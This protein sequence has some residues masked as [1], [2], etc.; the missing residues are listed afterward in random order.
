MSGDSLEPFGKETARATGELAKFGARTLDS[1]DKLFGYAAEVAATVP[2]DLIGLG[3]GDWLRETKLRNLHKLRTNTLRIFSERTDAPFEEI[4][5]SIAVP[6]IEAAANELRERLAEIWAKLLAAAA[7]P[8][9]R[10]FVRADLI[11]A[12]KQLEPLDAIVFQTVHELLK[13]GRVEGVTAKLTTKLS[14]DLNEIIVSL[15]NLEDLGLLVPS[16]DQSHASGKRGSGRERQDPG[17]G[18]RGHLLLKALS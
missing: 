1:L 18:P 16:A 6:L 7:D 12:V 5:P 9:R 8:N 4:S 3:G 15:L 10:A 2:H 13:D 17:I 11:S 14:V